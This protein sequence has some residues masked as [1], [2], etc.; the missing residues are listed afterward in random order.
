MYRISIMFICFFILHNFFHSAYSQLHINEASNKN[1]ST[2]ADE[3]NEYPDWIELYNAG[4]DSVSIYNYSLSDNELETQKWRFPNIKIGPHQYKIIFCSGKD[5]KPL[6][7]FTEVLN[8]SGLNPVVGWNNHTFTRPFYW[9]G[10]SNIMINTCSYSNTGYTTNSVFN[11]SATSYPSTVFSAVDG[12][13]NACFY[14]NGSI[15]NL[16]PNLKINGRTIGNGT[17]NNGAT[18]YPAPYGNWYWSARNQMLIPAAELQ[19]AGLTAGNIQSLG[20]DVV[21][22]DPNTVYTYFIINMKMVTETQVSSTFQPLNNELYLHTNFT[23]KGG[24]ESVFLFDASGVLVDSMKVDCIQ[25]DNSKGCKPD[26]SSERVFFTT[27]TPEATNNGSVPYLITLQQPV[28]SKPSG[29]YSSSQSISLN[30]PNA[31]NSVIHYTLDGS[32]PNP[33]SPI[34]S[35]SPI[36]FNSSVVIKAACFAT[37][38]IS[39]PVKANSYLIGISHTTPILS[40]ITAENNLYGSTGIFDNWSSDWQ[41]PAY[42]EYFNTDRSM[43]FSQPAAIQMDGGAGGSR[44]HPQHSFRL[45]L[46]NSVLGGGTVHYP[47]LPDRPNRN[48]YSRIYLRNGSNQFLRIPYKDACGVKVLCDETNNYYSAYRPVSV[49]I[50]GAYFGLY[51]LREKFDEEYFKEADG[52]DSCDL[53]SQS[54]WYGSVLRAVYGSVDSFY[55]YSNAFAQISTSDPDYW[56]KADRYFDM[57]YYTDYI[58]AESFVHNKDWPWNNIKIYRSE[59]TNWRYRFCVIDVELALDPFGWSNSNEDPIS[60]L[61]QQDPNIPYINIWLRSIQN[62]TYKRYFINRYADIINTAYLPAVLAEK[63]NKI[64]TEMNREMPKEFQRWG[65]PTN[66]PQQMS[67][68]NSNHLMLKSEYMSRGQKVRDFIEN[69]FQLQRQVEVTLDVYPSG[70]GKIRISTITPDQLPWK[71]IYFHG[72]PVSIE[73][74]ANPGYS[75]L[76]WD[77]NELISQ[78]DTSK[79][80]TFDIPSNITFKAVFATTPFGLPTTGAPMVLF[81]NPGN[82]LFSIYFNEVKNDNYSIHITNNIGQRVQSM[83]TSIVTGKGMVNPDL[84]AFPAGVY[85][86]QIKNKEDQWTLKY[87]K[88]TQ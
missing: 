5:R 69:G 27:P 70:A 66:I 55:R 80:L 79:T 38:Y 82:G 3:D 34:F 81:P 85:F 4:N 63:E 35:G 40:V 24:G 57:K 21:S 17:I 87:V 43:I 48:N 76:Y 42:A 36:S 22:T 77:T 78:L 30:N 37:G 46:D 67:D 13:D 47:L 15:A 54:Y 75:F 68:F 29:I 9:D 74:I 83:K 88:T 32:D 60:F 52:A 1:F 73:A 26:A 23:L 39:S 62:N 59:K 58:I 84:R 2:F 6:S 44:S 45:E 8:L 10:V 31:I 12:N 61:F 65:D 86:I 33:S 49:Y 16:R 7:G 53:L 72:N 51:E 64:F 14:P 71:G 18:D 50:N 56:N 20:F 19:A 28:F 11:Q 25:I 41:K